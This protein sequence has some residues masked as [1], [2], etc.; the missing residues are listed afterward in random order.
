[1]EKALSSWGSG[2]SRVNCW[3]EAASRWMASS[4]ETNQG[5]DLS[6][7]SWV[8]HWREQALLTTFKE[9]NKGPGDPD[10]SHTCNL[11][12]QTRPEP[13]VRKRNLRTTNH[14]QAKRQLLKRQPIK[15]CPCVASCFYADKV[16]LRVPVGGALLT[17]SG[18]ILP[19][20]N[21]CSLRWTRNILMCFSVSSNNHF[22][23]HSCCTVIAYF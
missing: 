14:K 22:L 16:S 3:E 17:T 10:G 19:N 9:L 15:S 7:A 13:P 5:G 21:P 2:R 11:G 1:M 20:S 8:T 23:R 12:K 6:Q 18:S 4:W